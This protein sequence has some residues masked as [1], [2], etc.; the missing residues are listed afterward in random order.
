MPGM[1]MS[2]R[3]TV[4]SKP[5]ATRSALG[6]SGA[7]AIVAPYVE[8]RSHISSRASLSSSTIRMRMPLSGSSGSAGSAAGR[9]G[10]A[11]R[12]ASAA[13]AGSVTRSLA[14]PPGWFVA[15]IVP[16]W[17]W[18]SSRVIARPRPRPP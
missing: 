2:L 12:G 10:G 14:P 9:D 16:P 4:G 15:V 5:G 17:S 7:S 11:A 13:I 3:I 18:T 6:P 8:S 1:P